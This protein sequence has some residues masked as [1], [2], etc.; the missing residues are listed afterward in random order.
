MLGRRVVYGSLTRTHPQMKVFARMRLPMLSMELER[1]ICGWS[2]M[3]RLLGSCIISLLG[4][5]EYL[6]N[7]RQ[8]SNT[9]N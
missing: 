9:V 7:S 4:G 5:V 8:C 6:R 3:D 1:G 2:V